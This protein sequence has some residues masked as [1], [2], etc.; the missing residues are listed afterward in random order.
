MTT[1]RRDMHRS[2]AIL[3]RGVDI[4][5]QLALSL[6]N[7]LKGGLMQN[8]HSLLLSLFPSYLPCAMIN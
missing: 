1:I 3:V 8:T 7:H 4:R 6:Y 2:N 5:S